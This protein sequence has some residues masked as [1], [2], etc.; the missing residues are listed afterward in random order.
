M[1]LSH[2]I[3]GRFGPDRVFSGQGNTAHR[4]DQQNTHLKISERDDIVAQPPKSKTHVHK[5]DQVVA[6]TTTTS[7]LRMFSIE[8]LF[9]FIKKTLI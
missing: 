3:A 7:T 2:I 5:I 8:S 6:K 9:N 4:N 1:G